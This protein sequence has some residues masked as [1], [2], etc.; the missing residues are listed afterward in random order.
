VTDGGIEEAIGEM[1]GRSGEKERCGL[2]GDAFAEGLGG[3]EKSRPETSL[4]EPLAMPLISNRK[5]KAG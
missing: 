4:N 5:L 1:N 2:A 3:G